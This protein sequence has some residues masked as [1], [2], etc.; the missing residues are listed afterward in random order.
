[1]LTPSDTIISQ[2]YIVQQRPVVLESDEQSKQE[3][4][5]PYKSLEQTP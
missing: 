2:N 5:E 1:M 3:L 4:W